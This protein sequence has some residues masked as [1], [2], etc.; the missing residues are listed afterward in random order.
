MDMKAFLKGKE[1]SL[2]EIEKEITERYTDENE[3]PVPFKFKAIESKRIDEIKVECTN[4]IHTKGQKVE[5]FNNDRF[6]AK[7]GIETTVFPNFKDK[8]LLESYNCV[9]P[10]DLAHEILKIPGEYSDWIETSFKVNGFDDTFEEL[11]ENAKN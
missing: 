5:K 8:E 10:I 6:A 2:P 9:D 4:I 11:V 1:K 7:V 3:K